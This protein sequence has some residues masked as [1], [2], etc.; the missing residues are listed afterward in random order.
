MRSLVIRTWR[1]T[2]SRAFRARGVEVVAGRRERQVFASSS[3][4]GTC[5]A[6]RV[7]LQGDQPWTANSF[8]DGA[9]TPIEFE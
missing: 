8:G 9:V 4:D 7:W 5:E 2:E 3:I 6:I 1:E